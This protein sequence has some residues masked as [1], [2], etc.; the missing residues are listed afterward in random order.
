M[1][2]AVE[3]LLSYILDNAVDDVVVY[4]VH[5]PLRERGR[6]NYGAAD[7]EIKEYFIEIDVSD[8]D[9]AIYRIAEEYGR[10]QIAH[11]RQKRE[12]YRKADCRNISLKLFQNALYYAHL[13]TRLH[14]TRPPFRTAT[15]R[16]RG[17]LRSFS[18]VLRAFRTPRA[19]RRQ[20]RVSCRRGVWSWFSAKL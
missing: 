12:E 13:R 8:I 1:L 6:Y 7:N 19:C 20:A 5:Y 9:Y 4:Y 10:E 18:T 2:K 15:R 16:F 14:I 17:K 11:Y 3:R